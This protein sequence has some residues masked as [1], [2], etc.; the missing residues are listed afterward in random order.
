MNYGVAIITIVSLGSIAE[1]LTGINKPFSRALVN[2]INVLIFEINRPGPLAIAI[3]AKAH[4][5]N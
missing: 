2:K 1:I 5:K 4:T 3:Q